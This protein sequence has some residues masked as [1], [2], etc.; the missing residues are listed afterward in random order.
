[1]R[2][3]EDRRKAVE[4]VIWALGME[5]ILA[6]TIVASGRTPRDVILNDAIRGCQAM[7]GIYGPQYGW[8]GA[9]SQQSP[10]EEEYDRARE[11]YKPIYAFIDRIEDKVVETR[12]Q[13]FLDKVQNWDFGV[14]RREFYSLDALQDLVSVALTGRDL[15]PHYQRF[16][17][18]L[19]VRT[20][21]I[22]GLTPSGRR[23][24]PSL[25]LSISCCTQPLISSLLG[26]DSYILVIDGDFYDRQET[27]QAI[28]TWCSEVNHFI[29]A[30]FLKARNASTSVLIAVENNP[31][32]YTKKSMEK[33]RSLFSSTNYDEMLV[34]LRAGKVELPPGN[35]PWFNPIKKAVESALG[36]E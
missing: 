6:E 12:Q 13:A 27:K 18:R 28:Q 24:N 22:N 4:V 29:G 11:L 2:E 7:V 23:A 10:T 26:L 25:L 16:L 9:Q 31:Y 21:N 14:L 1:M 5:P 17:D 19:K 35:K 20:G 8:T 36:N 33:N 32:D 3:Y 30:A 15:S 34:D